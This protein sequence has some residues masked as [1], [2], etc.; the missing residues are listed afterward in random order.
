M[1]YLKPPE[2]RISNVIPDWPK[3]SRKPL[4]V[5]QLEY[6]EKSEDFTL[7]E[8]Y[9]VDQIIA[10]IICILPNPCITRLDVL[11]VEYM[12]AAA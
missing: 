12:R 8:G 6:G 4:G 2:N 10:R 1:K 9:R 5:I 7:A 3:E 11:I